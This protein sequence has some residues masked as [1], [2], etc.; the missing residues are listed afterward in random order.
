MDIHEELTAV[1]RDIFGDPDLVLSDSTTADD[2]EMWDS[3]M[4]VVLIFAIEDGFGFKF[5]GSELET[6]SDV[7]T[8]KSVIARRLEAA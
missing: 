4:H 6:L 1:F 2:I 7:G 8:L 5:T 3:A